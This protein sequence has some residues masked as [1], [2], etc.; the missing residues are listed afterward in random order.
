MI[1]QKEEENN[2][3]IKLFKEQNDKEIENVIK[4]ERDLYKSKIEEE[5][6]KK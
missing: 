3:K 2:E 6:K 5:F 1:A 4:N